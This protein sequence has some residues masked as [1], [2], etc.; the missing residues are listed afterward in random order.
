MRVLLVLLA[1]LLL[2]SGYKLRPE[3]NV[4]YVCKSK[5]TYEFTVE[6][7]WS[8]EVRSCDSVRV[9]IIPLGE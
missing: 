4:L 3:G 6:G 7:D 8:L 5:R 1:M 9:V 2:T